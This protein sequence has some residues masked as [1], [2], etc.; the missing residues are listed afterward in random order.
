M[1]GQELGGKVQD[2][3]MAFTE[4]GNDGDVLMEA[5]KYKGCSSTCSPS[6][7]QTAKLEQIAP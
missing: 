4:L 3:L 1:Q 7:H 5:N 2:C 6:A